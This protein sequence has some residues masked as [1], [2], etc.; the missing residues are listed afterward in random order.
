MD[1]NLYFKQFFT[2]KNDILDDNYVLFHEVLMTI[3]NSADI[4]YDFYY[5]IINQNFNNNSHSYCGVEIIGEND[6]SSEITKLATFYKSSNISFGLVEILENETYLQKM[7][8]KVD[9]TQKISHSRWRMNVSVYI[10]KSFLLSLYEYEKLPRFLFKIVKENC[11]PLLTKKK[12][13]YYDIPT[14]TPF[15]N[16]YNTKQYKRELYDYQK[17]NVKWMIQTE[18]NIINSEVI[19]TYNIPTDNYIYNVKSID[20]NIISD[21]TGKILNLDE[22]NINIIQ[23]GAILSDE[24]GLGKT[25][26]ILSLITEQLNKNTEKTSLIFCPSRLCKQWVEEIEKTYDLKYKLI[27]SITQFKKLSCDDYNNY[28][29]IILSYSFLSNQNYINY[30]NLDTDNPKLLH[31]FKWN[32]IILDE[33]HEIINGSQ[34][35][36]SLLAREQL[37]SIKSN[38]RWICSGTPYGNKNDFKSILEY[39]SDLSYNTEQSHNYSLFLDKF[40]RK[41]TK[42]SVKEQINI[43]DAIVTTEFL[44]LSSLERVI[45]DSAL[46]NPDTQ[47]QYCN[48]I[49]VKEENLNI[50]GSKPLSLEEIKFKM[51]EYCKNK[52]EYYNK[53]IV[54]LQAEITKFQEEN[55][56]IELLNL[57]TIKLQEIQQK[58]QDVTCKFN[59]FTNIEDKLGEEETCPI[60]LEELKDLTTS[61]TPCGHIF[62]S[63]CLHNSNQHN[64]NKCPM[65]RSQFTLDQVKSIKPTNLTNSDDSPKLGTKIEYLIQTLQNIINNNNN[66][67]IIVFSQWDNMLKLISKILTDFNINHIFL[68]GSI[69]TISSKLRKFKLDTSINVVLMSSD[70]SPSGL[71]LT[72][73]SHI[74]LLD[75]L[76]T[77][78]ENALIIEQQAIGRA[79]RIGQT[80]NVNV[81]RFIMRNTIEHDYYIRNIES[82]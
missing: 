58:L 1:T 65:C 18:N 57:K 19:Q 17:D 80:K 2:K 67:K 72:E 47:I 3:G 30:C 44:N 79:V 28:D 11:E 31:N 42:D 37:F 4:N 66:D 36:Q 52:I 76:N 16:L 6:D 34:K 61:I 46:N 45:Y 68:N 75:S 41:N 73:A 25:F 5:F 12:I 22:N 23:K 29:I 39:I 9:F 53:R 49:Q 62:C 15:Y 26:S 14:A 21:T 64:S 48:S 82:N 33:G 20:E 7:K 77:T 43:P 69:H 24:V 50:L 60:C 63:N 51:T 32:R 74:I 40:F 56:C 78:K 13:N 8:L 54:N 71:N 55:Y 59:I 70:K 10:D 35:K 27:S 81:K 38:Y